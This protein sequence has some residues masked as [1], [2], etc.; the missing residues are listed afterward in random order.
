MANIDPFLSNEFKNISGIGSN[1]SLPMVIKLRD[2]RFDLDLLPDCFVLSILGDTVSCRGTV[3]T[4]DFMRYHPA[5]MS[6]QASQ[7]CVDD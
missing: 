6:V 7:T 2:S 4:L 1:T 5:I 3:K